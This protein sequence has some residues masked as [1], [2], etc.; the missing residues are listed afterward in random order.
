VDFDNA[1][2]RARDAYAQLST[3]GAKALEELQ[4]KDLGLSER[5]CEEFQRVMLLGTAW[6][7]VMRGISTNYSPRVLSVLVRGY[8]RAFDEQARSEEASEAYVR[9]GHGCA[10]ARDAYYLTTAEAREAY[11]RALLDC[12]AKSKAAFGVRVGT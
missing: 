7:A 10:L 8:R 1:L 12:E 5:M 11:G 3:T 4:L 2:T 6:F 9:L